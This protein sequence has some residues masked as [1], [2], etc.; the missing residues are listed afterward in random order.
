MSEATEFLA[1]V[2]IDPLADSSRVANAHALGR[3]WSGEHGWA[4]ALDRAREAL[5][6]SM[7]PHATYRRIASD[8][9]L[10]DVNGTR[11]TT[12]ALL[13]G[14]I[15]LVAFWSP[16]TTPSVQ[17]LPELEQSAVLLRRHGIRIVAVNLGRN[18][19]E[20][21]DLRNE[22]SPS[23]ELYF[24]PQQEVAAAFDHWAM[25]EFFVVDQAGIVRYRHSSLAMAIRQATSLTNS[26]THHLNAP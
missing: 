23:V 4:S 22:M 6:S 12:G 18:W 25:P 20:A 17:A 2:A 10:V 7:A 14:G 5:A 21:I 8:L 9:K 15:S 24:D 16:Q 19:A 13:T 26:E 1:R 3:S 11:V